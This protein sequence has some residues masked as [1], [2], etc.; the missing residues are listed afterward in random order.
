MHWRDLAQ[1]QR[2][3][4]LRQLAEQGYLTT[5]EI[6]SV[7]EAAG[8]L[9]VRMSERQ[10]REQE[11][12]RQRARQDVA[13]RCECEDCSWLRNFSLNLFDKFSRKSLGTPCGPL[14]GCGPCRESV[15]SYTYSTKSNTTGLVH[16][17]DDN[18]VVTDD[19]EVSASGILA[20]GNRDRQ[21]DVVSCRGVDFTEHRW[22]PIVLWD[23]GKTYNLPIGLTESEDGH[24][25]VVY[26]PKEDII[27]QKSFFA[28]TKMARQ[29]YSLIRQRYI[30]ANSVALKDLEVER[31]P[32]DPE[33]GHFKPGKYIRRSMLA[34]VT[35]TPLPA[36]PDAVA[37]LVGRGRIA[38][39]GYNDEPL[40]PLIMKSFEPFV[41]A[42]KAWRTA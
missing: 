7:A 19:K 31:L 22:N 6:E 23:H 8:N 34:E 32:P 26:H 18:D 11:Q 30:R 37:S 27:T 10:D 4:Q 39:E 29:I 28:P 9:V 2:I 36:N 15:F 40:H 42:R 16:L 33:R 14:C 13:C 24:Y 5:R 21:G 25:T 20:S 38:G 1:A 17:G 12:A 41:P 35:W 3:K